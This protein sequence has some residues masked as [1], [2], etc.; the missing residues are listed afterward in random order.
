MAEV[1]Y[2]TPTNLLNTTA[3]TPKGAIEINYKT[4]QKDLKYL[5]EECNIQ[6]IQKGEKAMT[7]DEEIKIMEK[8]LTALKAKRDKKK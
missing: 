6:D 5:R 4:S 1:R 2:I 3:Y 7:L 8:D